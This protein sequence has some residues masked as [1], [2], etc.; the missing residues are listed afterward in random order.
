MML[1][2]DDPD[3]GYVSDKMPIPNQVTTES[4]DP[5]PP[6]H[7]LSLNAIKGTNNMGVLRFSGA[8]DHINVQILIDGGSSDNFLQPRIAKFLR[9]PVEPG[10]VFKVLVGN[11]DIMNAEG[12]IHKLPLEVLGHKLEVPVYLLPVAGA[13]VILGAKGVFVWEL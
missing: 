5:D 12:V 6:Q 13:D 11:G 4:L 10:P 2:Y 9:L 3:E 1:S 7:H 8:I